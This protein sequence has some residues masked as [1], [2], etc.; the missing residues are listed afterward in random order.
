MTARLSKSHERCPIRTRQ[1]RPA[2]CKAGELAD[3]MLLL[4]S[5]PS[6]PIRAARRTNGYPLACLPANPRLGRSCSSFPGCQV[7]KLPANLENHTWKWDL[8]CAVLFPSNPTHPAA[9]SHWMLFVHFFGRFPSSRPF[10]LSLAGTST[11]RQFRYPRILAA[12]G[13]LQATDVTGSVRGRHQASVTN[14]TLVPGARFI[15]FRS[16]LS[17]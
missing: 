13:R 1:P 3:A 2:R 6:Q 15:G 4:H 12:W 5:L 16:G 10:F 8:H 7:A 11:D 9:S 17:C 14:A